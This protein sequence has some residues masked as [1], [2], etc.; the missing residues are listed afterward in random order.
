[1]R[2]P[3]VKTALIAAAAPAASGCSRGTEANNAAANELDAN[4]TM[5]EP[6]NDQSAID[7]ATNLAEPVAPVA[8]DSGE[9]GSDTG[10]DTG[11]NNVESNTVGM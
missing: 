5:S 6:V 2:N 1:M 9:T 10:G 8:N 3:T 4:M 11:G 7:S